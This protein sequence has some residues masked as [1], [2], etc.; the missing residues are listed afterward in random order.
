[1]E[2]TR[3]EWTFFTNHTHVLVCLATNPGASLR[4]V[5]QAIGITERAV[6][7]IV[8]D[9]E[10]AGVLSRTRE[11]RSNRYTLH[12]DQPLRHPLERHRRIGEVLAPL[13]GPA[14]DPPDGNLTES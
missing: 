5:A 10:Q 4:Q 9:L 12:L 13:V 2:P 11:G 7:R 1:M 8:S 3:P 14:S 6:Q